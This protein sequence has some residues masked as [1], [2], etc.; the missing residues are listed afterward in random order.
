MTELAA[1][2]L[3]EM[4]QQVAGLE[5][6]PAHSMPIEDRTV[7]IAPGLVVRTGT[8]VSNRALVEV[9]DRFR[10]ALEDRDRVAQ[11][12]AEN[13][14][15]SERV[16]V[17]LAAMSDRHADE[18]TIPSSFDFLSPETRWAVLKDGAALVDRGID[19]HSQV[20]ESR[21]MESISEHSISIAEGERFC[22]RVAPYLVIID[23]PGE[24]DEVR[25][26]LVRLTVAQLANTHRQREQHEL[27]ERVRD[28][29]T[30]RGPT[31]ADVASGAASEYGAV[32]EQVSAL[33]EET[34]RDS[35]TRIYNRN[36]VTAVAAELNALGQPYSVVMADIDHF[37]AINDI[38]GHL[39]GDK[40]IVAV[41][42]L[43]DADSRP[44]DTVARWGGEEF[45]AVLP[46]TPLAEASEIA[47]RWR[48]QIADQQVEDAAFTCSFGV[49]D[50]MPGM[51][52]EQILQRADLALYEA[53]SKGRDRVE[54]FSDS[55]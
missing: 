34:I 36:K 29:V 10:L 52:F 37:K 24:I 12:E 2:A 39:V 48:E 14:L 54:L 43:L 21:R 16:G 26:Q 28:L 53:K 25:R 23:A 3:L 44:T 11:L 7:T 49:C 38:Y 8:E 47:N 45:V 13:Q 9:R 31:P 6:L 51:R 17:L 1:A 20:V 19:R 27:I 42:A 33:I 22:V 15:L 35:L 4:V 5:L 46:D 30:S 41:A 55:G 50:S 40:V 32:D 18:T